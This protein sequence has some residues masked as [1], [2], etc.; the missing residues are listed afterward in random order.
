MKPIVLLFCFLC[1]CVGSLQAAVLSDTIVVNGIAYIPIDSEKVQ[2]VAKPSGVYAGDIVVPAG[3]YVDERPYTVIAVASKAFYGCKGV[4]SVTLPSTV[5]SFGTSAFAGCG[6]THFTLPPGATYVG[7]SMFSQ[8]LNL[9]SVYIPSSVLRI[10]DQAFYGCVSLKNIALPY[11]VTSIGSK[12]FSKSGLVTAA[13]PASVS[14][15]GSYAFSETPL[16]SIALSTTLR[17]VEEGVF[18][19][20]RKLKEVEIPDSV[21]SIGISAFQK[22][23]SLT[24]LRLPVRLD[25]IGINGFDSCAALQRIR[26]L[27]AT[28][29]RLASHALWLVP[30][31]AQVEVPV[32]ALARYSAHP[33]WGKFLGLKEAVTNEVSTLTWMNE[34]TVKVRNGV[35]EWMSSGA[36]GEG[37]VC[38]LTGEVLGRLSDAHPRLT[39][40]HRG[41][42]LIRS[43]HRVQK[44]LY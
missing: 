30:L 39:L 37:I 42:Y 20:C 40:P 33:T 27:T 4:T 23:V 28:P 24:D 26:L 17:S 18:C 32:G 41:L 6:F 11:A 44:I 1:A 43:A 7:Y 8:C 14:Y 10:L 13:L 5:I 9:S 2:V 3:I 38:T 19:L 34:C 36:S 15:V 16:T 29:P 25:T 31:T 35:L 21:K 22:C 12:A